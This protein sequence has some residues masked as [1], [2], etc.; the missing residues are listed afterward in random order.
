MHAAITWLE[1]VFA[2]I[3]LGLLEV[4][5]RFGY[6]LGF[7]LML[8][9]YGGFVFGTDGR[10]GLGRMRQSWN[11]KAMS[12]AVITFVSIFVTGYIGSFIVLVPG[13]QT[14]ESLKD[15]SVFL[16]VVLFGYPALLIVPFAYGLSDL[17]EGVPPAFLLDWLPGYFINPACFWLAHQLIGRNPDFRRSS[18]WARY[19]LF[20]FIFMAIEPQLWGYITSP[21]F[22]PALAYRSVSSALFF[23]TA[24]TWILAPL[25]MLLAL[26]LARRYHMFWAG[27]PG[28]VRE[29]PLGSSQWKWVN[30]HD[31]R[32]LLRWDET[33]GMPLRMLLATP[34]IVMMLATIGIT[35]WLTLGSAESGSGKLASR[36]HEEISFNIRQQ[37]DDYLVAERQSGHALQLEGVS[38][39][40]KAQAVV[41]HGQAFIISLDGNLLASSAGPTQVAQTAI[42]EL[43]HANGPLAS[44]ARPMQYE[45]DVVTSKPLAR[46]TWMSQATPYRSPDG[47]ADWV[48]ITVMPESYYLEGVRTGNSQ[49]AMVLAWALLAALLAAIWLSALVTGPV[50]G[51]ARAAHAIAGGDMG[52]RVPVGR[53]HEL[54]ALSRAFNHMATQLQKSFNDLQTMA[55]ALAARE[56]SLEQSQARYRELSEGLEKQVE[57][58][59]RELKVALR[60]AEAANQ[61]KSAFLSNMSHELRTPLN[62]VI[63][64]S[65]LLAGQRETSEDQRGKLGMINRAGHHL[66]TLI[67]DILDLSKIEAG[68]AELNLVPVD[69]SELFATVLDMVRLRARQT[70][71]ALLLECEHAPHAVLADG[72]KLRQVLLNLL[73]NAVKFTT[74][75]SVTLSVRSEAAGAHHVLLHFAVRDTGPGISGDDQERIFHPFVQGAG[76]QAHSGTGLGL[77]IVRDYVH[78]MGG[79]VTLESSPGAGSTFSFSIAATL[80]D[81]S[82]LPARRTERVAGLPAHERGKVVL[83]VDDSTESRTLLRGLLEP[84]GFVTMETAD[85]EDGAARVLAMQPD[86][87]LADWRMPKRD[88]L[89]LTRFIRAQQGIRQPRIVI[90][91]ASAF[92]AE[93]REALASGADEFIR[94]PIEQDQLFAAIERQLG[95]HFLREVTTSIE[96]P[97]AAAPETPLPTPTGAELSSMN[98]RLRAELRDA[99]ATLNT[100]RI[101]HLLLTIEATHPALAPRIRHML[102]R[103]E[104]QQLWRLLGN[105]D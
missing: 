68:R 70:G 49:S 38:T 12:S 29:R 31:E 19:A 16:C 37:L 96:V 99:I 90:Q 92:E 78:L 5:G 36:L 59:T 8:C 25:A 26:P 17:I 84:L 3:P 55:R 1:S 104:H 35:A 32:E 7:A 14:F 85:G 39:L 45:F 30:A 4:W 61:A 89:S 47:S 71:V 50:R 97:D 54:S 100:H 102:E 44:L 52:Q 34:V 15:L 76:A 63:G 28:H 46:E 65:D 101:D 13:A 95:L 74:Q 6:L 11:G 79:A 62:A 81:E 80:A 60:N 27:I 69:L 48:L 20:V 77:A 87:V 18:V 86:L 21:Q 83:I 33:P 88:G 91:S 82:A 58:R 73:S 94:K 66:L 2:A 24:I 98:A 57:E 10:W 51:M 64:F 105:A 42:N 9:A 93:R 41:K 56:K 75:G 22:T 72:P 103:A 40:L 23:T 67:N 43:R 53:V